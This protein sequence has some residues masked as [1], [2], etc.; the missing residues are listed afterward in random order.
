MPVPVT[1][2]REI[3][4]IRRSIKTRLSL[5]GRFEL[6]AGIGFNSKNLRASACPPRNAARTDQSPESI[7]RAL[8]SETVTFK[9]ESLVAYELSVC[10]L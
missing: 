9:S 7:R 3:G 8:A 1:G 2:C 4:E 6:G 10:I 5:G